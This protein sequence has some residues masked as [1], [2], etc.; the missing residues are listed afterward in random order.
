MPAEDY[1]MFGYRPY[2]MTEVQDDPLTI[3]TPPA[4]LVR[5]VPKYDGYVIS[6]NTTTPIRLVGVFALGLVLWALVIG[7]GIFIAK[8]L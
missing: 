7:V 3:P 5:E 2:R 4:P 1:V 6:G 8:H